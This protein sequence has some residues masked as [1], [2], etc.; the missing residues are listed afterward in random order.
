MLIYYT[1]IKPNYDLININRGS[2]HG[3]Y[4]TTF[5]MLPRFL[6]YHGS[7]VTT[8]PMLPRFILNN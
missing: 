5:P 7:Y 3:F 1:Y 2:V 8:V 4:V 6:C